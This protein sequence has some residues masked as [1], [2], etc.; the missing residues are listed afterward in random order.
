MSA[1]NYTPINHL[2]KQA[3]G[4][5][6]LPKE[7]EPVRQKTEAVSLVDRAEALGRQPA[8]PSSPISFKPTTINLPPDLKK[9]GLR[10]VDTDKLPE[11]ARVSLPI[12]DAKILPGLRAPI[13]SSLRWLATLALYLLK[14]AH[15]QLKVIHGHVVRTLK[16]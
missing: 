11:Y 1:K 6:S 16:T 14:K 8:T 7:S 10:T 3:A 13:T 2:L 15:L 4:P 9:I 12:A 5:V